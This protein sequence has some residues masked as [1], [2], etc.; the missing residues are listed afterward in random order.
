MSE[1]L[2]ICSDIETQKIMFAKND[3]ENTKILPSWEWA[4]IYRKESER[5]MK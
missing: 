2:S 5:N 4:A 1:T 3:G